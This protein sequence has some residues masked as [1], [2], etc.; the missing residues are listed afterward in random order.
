[1]TKISRA[2]NVLNCKYSVKVCRVRIPE[3]EYLSSF[4]L[5]SNL[6]FFQKKEFLLFYGKAFSAL[7][8]L[9]SF[10][11]ESI[12]LDAM[13]KQTPFRYSTD[14][15]D[16]IRSGHNFCK[17]ETEDGLKI[18]SNWAKEW[19]FTMIRVSKSTIE[20]LMKQDNTKEE[21]PEHPRTKRVLYNFEVARA[22]FVS[23]AVYTG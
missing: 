14:V 17:W 2:V 4:L 6:F 12:A 10:A 13:T 7:R 19:T 23:I 20:W 11:N 5:F 18:L 9:N 22:C 1:M 21:K 16:I 3:F 8:V 15:K